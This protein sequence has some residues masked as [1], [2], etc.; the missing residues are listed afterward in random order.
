MAHLP[1]QNLWITLAF[2][3]ARI[4]SRKL[5]YSQTILAGLFHEVQDD[6]MQR[7]LPRFAEDPEGAGRGSLQKTERAS[8]KV[9]SW[10]EH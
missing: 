1:L 4:L 5:L 7:G 6:E 8:R 2:K 3:K 10:A 9:L